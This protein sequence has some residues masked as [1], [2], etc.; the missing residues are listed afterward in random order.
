MVVDKVQEVAI[1][2]TAVA[3]AEAEATTNVAV[4]Q[5]ARSRASSSFRRVVDMVGSRVEGMVA[6]EVE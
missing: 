6:N 5:A 1:R 2:V 4:S 3:E